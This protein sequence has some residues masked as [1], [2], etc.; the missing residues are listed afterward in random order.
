MPTNLHWPLSSSWWWCCFLFSSQSFSSNHDTECSD[1][2]CWLQYW[3][4]NHEVYA[5]YCGS[6]HRYLVAAL[7]V[8]VLEPCVKLI[9]LGRIYEDRHCLS[10]DRVYRCYRVSCVVHSGGVCQSR[11]IRQ[12]EQE[13]MPQMYRKHGWSVVCSAPRCSHYFMA[14]EVLSVKTLSRLWFDSS[15]CIEKITSIFY[16]DQDALGYD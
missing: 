11:S 14:G 5:H 7:W 16:R 2:R 10:S 8:V 9:N 15:S 4:K 13:T 1:I 6:L 12:S 3:S